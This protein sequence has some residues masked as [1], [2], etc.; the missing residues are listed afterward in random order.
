ME[1]AK[2]LVK[3]KFFT[4]SETVELLLPYLGAFNI[5]SLT[6]VFPAT[7]KGT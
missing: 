3:D 4:A 6:N 5:L 2:V 1:D 7:V